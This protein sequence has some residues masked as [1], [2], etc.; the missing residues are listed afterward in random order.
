M[1][2]IS[3]KYRSENSENNYSLDVLKS[4]L[5]KYIRRGDAK[6]SCYILRE[7]LSFNTINEKRL[8]LGH[9]YYKI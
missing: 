6:M 3:V 9:K 7:F 8:Y 1:S 5:Q 4:A 2:S